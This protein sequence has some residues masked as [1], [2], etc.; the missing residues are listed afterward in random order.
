MINILKIY[1][2]IYLLIYLLL[3]FI[4]P[5]YRVYRL[6][7]INP[8]TF[9]RSDS[10]HDYIGFVM[11]LIILGI[12]LNIC[13]YSISDKY[14]DFLSPI[15]YL[16]SMTSKI[17]GLV[18]IHFSLIWISVA[19][20]QMKENWRIGIDEMNSTNLVTNGVFK[21][22]R[23]PV[24]LGMILSTCGLFLILPNVL[25]FTSLVLTYFVIQ[26]QIRLEE[27]YL[28]VQH[29]EKYTMYLLQTNRLI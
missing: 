17:I 20:K 12:A 24:F 7:G 2:P 23:N 28:K 29:G 21:I 11:K 4:I 13:I 25:S 10:V 5:T 26:I 22:S 16:D 8:I 6:K 19:Q 9:K 14:Y 27:A 15:Q 18:I 3:I 1:L